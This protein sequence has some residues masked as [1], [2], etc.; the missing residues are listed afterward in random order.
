MHLNLSFPNKL[1]RFSKSNNK[2][3]Q[4]PMKLI[5]LDRARVSIW[6]GNLLNNVYYSCSNKIFFKI[7]KQ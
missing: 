3:I 1:N 7:L 2:Y 5:K 4:I 6:F